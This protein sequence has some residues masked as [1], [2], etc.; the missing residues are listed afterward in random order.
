[1]GRGRDVARQR[2]WLAQPGPVIPSVFARIGQRHYGHVIASQEAMTSACLAPRRTRR[3][4]SVIGAAAGRILSAIVVV[5][6]IFAWGCGGTT[7]A[8]N[9]QADGS[10]DGPSVE[11]SGVP[12]LDSATSCDASPR[13]IQ[14]S[15]YD[16]TC[17]VDSDCS[18][19]T[20]GNSCNPCSLNCVNAAINVHA[21]SAYTSDNAN[22]VASAGEQCPSSCGGPEST[23]C[24][25]GKCQ[26][27]Y[28][29]CPYPGF[30]AADASALDASSEACAPSG[31]TGYC[32]AGSHNVSTIA[33]GCL[34][35]HCCVLDDAGGQD[36]AV[37]DGGVT[38]DA[39]GDS[40]ICA[41]DLDCGAGDL[42]GFPASAGCSASGTCF[43]RPGA[44]CDAIELGCACDGTSINLVCNGLPG[45][46]TTKLFAHTGGC[47]LDSGGGD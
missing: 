42:C 24:R 16:Q 29:S 14:A 28:P 5:G 30:L 39:R 18:G 26:W 3:S 21:L 19:I 8:A 43:P 10:S 9:G 15:R 33:N 47:G 7:A 23:C 36:G 6:G 37:T 2:S 45:G 35:W 20:E 31:C 17:T 27:G 12:V 32:T 4:S 40:G 34:V 41:T 13:I 46:Y 1:M 22:L 25:S 38:T 11:G 44:M